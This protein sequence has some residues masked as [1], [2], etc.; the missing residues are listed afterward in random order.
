M[1]PQE[2]EEWFKKPSKPVNSYLIKHA[3]LPEKEF[4]IHML[5][6]LE[7][8]DTSRDYDLIYYLMNLIKERLN[9]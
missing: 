2:L 6:V 3:K 1:N 8:Y 9:E 7:D 4:L 5:E